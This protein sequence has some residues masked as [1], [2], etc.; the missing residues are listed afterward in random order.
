MT[1]A[2][3]LPQEAYAWA[4]SDLPGISPVRL[5][6]L[7]RQDPPEAA[8]GRVLR[9]EVVRPAPSPQTRVMGAR[10]TWADVA[11]RRDLGRGWAAIRSAG[12][13]VTYLGCAGLAA[14]L[15]EDPEPPGVLFWLGDLTALDR[16]CVAIVGTRHCTGYG[17]AVAIELGRDLAEC[18]ICVV[19]G[20]ALGIDGAAHV[21]ALAAGGAG[22]LGV[23]ASGVDMPYPR[24]HADLWRRV[25]A[26]GA[27]ISETAPGRPAQ[28]WRFPARNRLIAALARAV[29]V[30][31]SHASGGSML[32]VAAAAERG[33]DV[34]AVPG[35]ITSASSAGTNQLLHEGLTPVRHAG[36]VLAALGDLRPWPPPSRPTRCSG[37]ASGSGG[38]R[39]SE[40]TRH[41]GP[42]M[43]G[44]VS[45]ERPARPAR[46]A[47]GLRLEP[48]VR[49]VLSAID[50]TS[51]ATSVI[52]DR[53]GLPI[54][55]LSSVLLHLETLGLIRSQGMWW[56][57]CP[58][59]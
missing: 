38:S 56:E 16:P 23:A 36:D 42:P 59:P 6:A 34:L 17:R 15:S 50:R 1:P 13:G 48:A 2:L 44:V 21:G 30:V 28:A 18:G 39:G 12:I 14:T 25:V 46:P 29:V 40:A 33:I 4:L 3:G 19:S 57:R 49:Q 31:E 9:G 26:A 41:S 45:T 22:P 8:W 58:E 11:A 35:P 51:T 24:R 37:P 55:P 27:V 5:V 52:A 43:T 10:P 54:G 32:T 7:L 53:T 47:E 20:L